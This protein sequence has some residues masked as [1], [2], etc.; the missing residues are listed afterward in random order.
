MDL[1][2]GEI[3][4]LFTQGVFGG[5]AEPFSSYMYNPYGRLGYIA[6]VLGDPDSLCVQGLLTT[7]NIYCV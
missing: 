6:S 4:L 7:T 5:R 2:R 1:W 3:F